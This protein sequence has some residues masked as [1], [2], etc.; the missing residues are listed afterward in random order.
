MCQPCDKRKDWMP[1][2]I[3]YHKIEMQGI[4]HLI[5]GTPNGDQQPPAHDQVAT[6]LL[7]P[8]RQTSQKGRTPVVPFSAGPVNESKMLVDFKKGGSNSWSKRLQ[9]VILK[10]IADPIN[11][12]D[13]KIGRAVVRHFAI[14]G[15]ASD[16]ENINKPCGGM[17]KSAKSKTNKTIRNTLSGLVIMMLSHDPALK[18]TIIKIIFDNAAK[19]QQISVASSPLPLL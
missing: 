19:M 12:Q 3:S 5:H 16:K 15:G 4:C 9:N 13:G 7:N 2:Y 6:R 17:S 1:G 8:P 10:S 14:T 11:A 18:S